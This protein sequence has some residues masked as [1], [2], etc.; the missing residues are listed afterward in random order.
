MYIDSNTFWIVVIIFGI[1]ISVIYYILNNKIKVLDKKI[2]DRVS[3]IRSLLDGMA[4]IGDRQ[5]TDVRNEAYR[6][7]KEIQNT[8]DS[9]L[10]EL[11]KK[12]PTTKNK[13]AR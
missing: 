1:A 6:D 7:K 11:E 13:K 4:E 3:R 8:I 5:I 9:A 2:D 10:K 12:S